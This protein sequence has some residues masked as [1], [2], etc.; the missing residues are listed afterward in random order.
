[1]RSARRVRSSD[2]YTLA[3]RDLPWT[4]VLATTAATMLGGGASVGMVSRVAEVGIAAAVVTCAWHLQ[5]IFT[6]LFVAPRL[7]GLKLIT[8]AD[9]FQLRFGPLARELAVVN[10]VIFLVGAL[11]AQM[12]AIGTVTHTVLGIPFGWALLIGAVVTIFYSTIGGL[13]AVVSTDVMQFVILVIGIGAASGILLA[14][15]GG[16]ETLQAIAGAEQF[17]LTSRWSLTAIVSIFFAY[18]LGEMFVPPYTV[19]CFIAR[20]SAH[21]RWGVALAVV[22]SCCCFCRSPRSCWVPRLRPMDTSRPR[23]NAK[24]RSCDGPPQRRDGICPRRLPPGKRLKL[25]F[26]R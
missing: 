6:G 2:D 8:V 12:A 18:L 19:R 15:Q 13:R 23:S 10:C 25:P 20:N 21:A 14:R 11:A 9:F 4:V 3:G 26:P 16:F 22:F 24:R 17:Q 1:M 5:L 7:R